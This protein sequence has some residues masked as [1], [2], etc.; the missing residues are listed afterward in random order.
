M[1]KNEYVFVI[2]YLEYGFG[3][4]EIKWDLVIVFVNFIFFYEIELV[5]FIK[6]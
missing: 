1:K 2:I 4:E 3:G 6:V 5:E